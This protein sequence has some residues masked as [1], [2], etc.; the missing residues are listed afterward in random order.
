MFYKRVILWKQGLHKRT[1]NNPRGLENKIYT[2]MKESETAYGD[3]TV[4]VTSCSEVQ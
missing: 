4:P 3:H 2:M 1:E